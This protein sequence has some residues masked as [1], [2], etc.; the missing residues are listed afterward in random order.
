MKKNCSLRTYLITFIILFISSQ[1]LS[2]QNQEINYDSDRTLKNEQ[3][4]PGALILSKVDNQVYF[5]HDG[6]EVWCDNAVFYKNA[7]FFKAY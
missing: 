7:N 6:I 4:Y 5:D 2:Q 1:L 3:R